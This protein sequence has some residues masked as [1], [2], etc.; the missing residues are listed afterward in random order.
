LIFFQNYIKGVKMSERPGGN[1][2]KALFS[3]AKKDNANNICKKKN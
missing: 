1:V 2:L 3:G